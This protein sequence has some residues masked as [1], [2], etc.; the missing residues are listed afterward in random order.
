MNQK[1]ILTSN[2]SGQ[3]DPIVQMSNSYAP[4]ITTYVNITSIL[5]TISLKK[6]RILLRKS[7]LAMSDL[8]L[9]IAIG[10]KARIKRFETLISSSK[11]YL[12]TKALSFC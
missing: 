12:C 1:N 7:A 5:A 3:R 8:F 10:L 2:F 4:V 9:S 6:R 11:S